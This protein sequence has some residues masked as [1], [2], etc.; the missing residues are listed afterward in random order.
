MSSV[1][2]YLEKMKEQVK[3]VKMPALLQRQLENVKA[4]M[5]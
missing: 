5:L 3:G 4:N 1:I 2:G